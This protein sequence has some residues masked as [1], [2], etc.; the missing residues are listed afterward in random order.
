MKAK[1]VGDTLYVDIT[2]GNETLRLTAGI[3]YPEGEGPFPAIIGIGFGTGSLPKE[4]FDKRGVAQIAFS[5]QQVMSHTQKRGK[6]PIN[7]LYPD[8]IEI[9]A[10]QPSL[11]RPDGYGS[12]LRLALGH[13]S[14]N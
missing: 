11:S 1:I 6:E 5:F 2:V 8:Q 13:K 10:Y 3:K 4:I 14:N 12:L 7:R 9:G